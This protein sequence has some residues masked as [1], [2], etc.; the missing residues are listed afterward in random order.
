MEVKKLIDVKKVYGSE[1]AIEL[2][3]K[4]STV[5]FDAGV[6]VHIRLGID[7]KKGDQQIRASVVLPNGTGKSKKIAVF[8][9]AETMKQAKEAGAD[10][11]ID[12]E[13][14]QQ[15]K[16]TEKCD[17]DV[18]IATPK[19]MKALGPIAKV[20]GPKGLMPSPKD[21]TVTMDM[22]T[23]VEAIKKGKATFKNDATGN[24][25]VL[26]GK[27]SFDTKKLMENFETLIEVLKKSKPSSSKGTFLKKVFISSSM[28][29]S[30]KV[31]V[32]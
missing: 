8:A 13:G 25:H 29:P 10:L 2:V 20:L 4:T 24:L 16:Q 28:G 6:E 15:I 18:A 30:V 9:D 22:K 31:Q 19:M 26:I 32:S 27:T 12:E 21:G 17:F 11:I 1:E 3:K 5:K 23:A 14:I 7:P